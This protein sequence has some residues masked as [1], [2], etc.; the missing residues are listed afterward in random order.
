[1]KSK[2]SIF[3]ITFILSLT[4][5]SCVYSSDVN[6]TAVVDDQLLIESNVVYEDEIADVNLYSDCK[7]FDYENLVVEDYL[8][9]NNYT[10]SFEIINNFE[11]TGTESDFDIENHET[12]VKVGEEFNFDIEGYESPINAYSFNN[13]QF[14]DMNFESDDELILD[15]TFNNHIFISSLADVNFSLDNVADFEILLI[16]MEDFDSSLFNEGK[17]KNSFPIQHELQVYILHDN[18]LENYL[19]FNII[20][21][22]NKVTDNFAYSI[23]NSIS[24]DESSV[25]YCSFNSHYP[26]QPFIDQNFLFFNKY[27][28]YC[29]YF[30]I[31]LSNY[32]NSYSFCNNE[33]HILKGDF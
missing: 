26:I 30:S 1:M 13:S 6:E 21:C 24:D 25:V 3:A 14:C 16:K 9:N 15:A 18:H 2:L 11:Y 29:F 17:F 7:G 8:I 5:L 10:T 20:I 33:I 31:F 23:N 32:K 12:L 27:T 19:N 28:T 22:S 4:L